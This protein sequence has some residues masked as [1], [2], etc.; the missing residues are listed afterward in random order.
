MRTLYVATDTTDKWNFGLHNDT[1]PS[2]PHM[3]R[4]AWLYDAGDGAEPHE[5]EA[6]V[7]KP[8]P[9]WTISPEAYSKAHGINLQT[10]KSVGSELL[11]VLERFELTLVDTD[12]IVGFPIDFQLKVLKRTYAEAG[13][14]WAHERKMFDAMRE[15]KDIVRKQRMAPG[16]GNSPFVGFAEA[17]KFFTGQSWD[18]PALATAIGGGKLKVEA[19]RLI[20]RGI[21]AARGQRP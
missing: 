18:N 11:D 20:H 17:Y 6:Y 3:I 13:A 21:L 1:H 14:T 15:C 8:G 2:Q 16:G 5:P 12:Q 7:I 4:L 19:L 9:D 10:A